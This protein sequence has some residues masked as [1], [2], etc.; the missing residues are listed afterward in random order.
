MYKVTPFGYFG[1]IQKVSR[2]PWFQELQAE[3]DGLEKYY[4]YNEA[5]QE[6]F[7]L[8]NNIPYEARENFARLYEGI[9]RAQ[10]MATFAG[11]WL[12]VETVLKVQRFRVMA[13]G[14]RFVSALAVA[15]G[16]KSVFNWWNARTYG[17]LVGAYVKKYGSNARS[18]IF[19]IRDEKREWFELDTRQYMSYTFDDLEHPHVHHGP[20]PDDE[21]QNSSW[22]VELDKHLRGEESN[23]K[24]HRNYVNYKFEYLDKS[25]PTVDAAKDIFNAPEP[26]PKEF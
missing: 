9:N 23:I 4:T 11:L 12:G 1:R 26:A 22:L 19:E 2:G 5:G 10:G 21:V 16:F 8:S 14:W 25:Y 13:P 15:Y 24:K 3:D 6:M 7:L 17:P 20:Q 18:D